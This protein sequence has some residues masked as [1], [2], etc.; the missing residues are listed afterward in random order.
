M[1]S[2]DN[3]YVSMWIEDGILFS[4]YKKKLAIDLDI[5]KKIVEDRLDFTSGKSY[6]IVIDF[7][8]MK[9]SNK[10]A[11]DFMN[12]PKGGLKG[13]TA[14]AFLSNNA[15]ATLFINLYLKI[16]KP[17]V[18]AKFFTSKTEAIDWIKSLK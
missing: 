11:R 2:R 5:A 13:L 14:G 8:N 15:V 1:Q 9:S 17:S 10:E 16:N 3:D 6:P 4:N 18:P 7:S 12:D